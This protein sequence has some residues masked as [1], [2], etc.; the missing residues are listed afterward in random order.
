M[1][2]TVEQVA[3]SRQVKSEWDRKEQLSQDVK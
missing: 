3:V 2:Q 1:A